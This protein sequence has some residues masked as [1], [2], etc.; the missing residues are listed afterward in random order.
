MTFT[1][2]NAEELVDEVKNNKVLERKEQCGLRFHS[3][4]KRPWDGD[5]VQ[6]GH[7]AMLSEAML[8]I[9]GKKQD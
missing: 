6:V 1:V 4:A 9:E 5:C 7:R 8:M 2:T 3:S